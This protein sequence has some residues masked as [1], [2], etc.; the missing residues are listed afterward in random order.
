MIPARFHALR[1]RVLAQVDH[2]FAEPVRFSPMR[3]KQSDPDR[4]QVQIEAVLRTS[5]NNSLSPT[6]NKRDQSWQMK[7][8]SQRSELHVDRAVYADIEFKTG[9][10]ICALSRPGE[11]V[12]EVA[13]V[14]KRGHTRTVLYLGEA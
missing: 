11:P 2:V 3:N 1:N 4:P 6:G 10:R 13:E 9:D 7:I 14:G 12:F 8:A 5:D